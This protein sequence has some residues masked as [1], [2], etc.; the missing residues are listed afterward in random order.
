MRLYRLAGQFRLPALFFS[1]IFFSTVYGGGG[2]DFTCTK[3][4]YTILKNKKHCSPL[5][6]FTW[7]VSHLIQYMYEFGDPNDDTITLVKELF[8][9][10]PWDGLT[11]D[12][13]RMPSRLAFYF[14]PKTIGLLICEI[15]H[16]YTEQSTISELAQS[17]REVL[18]EH[19]AFDELC[20]KTKKEQERVREICEPKLAA[21]NQQKET[22]EK[23]CQCI[24][25]EK[26]PILA[27]RKKIEIQ[28]NRARA[29][30]N[31]LK[32]KSKTVAGMQEKITHKEQEIKQIQGELRKQDAQINRLIQEAKCVRQEIQNNKDAIRKIENKIKNTAMPITSLDEFVS[33]IIGAIKESQPGAAQ[34]YVPYTVYNI[35]LAFL[36]K[37]STTK[38]DFLDYFSGALPRSALTIPEILDD[39]SPEQEQWL[40]AQYERKSYVELADRLPSLLKKM[41]NDLVALEMFLEQ[42]Y[43]LLISGLH[44]YGIYSSAFPPQVTYSW[45]TYKGYFFAD[46]GSN[47]L[48]NCIDNLIYDHEQGVFD[49]SVFR[50]LFAVRPELE[51][52]YK[53]HGSIEK[54]ETQQARDAWVAVTS[55]LNDDADDEDAIDYKSP[56]QNGICEI[57]ARSGIKNMMCVIRKLFG[58]KDIG[59]LAQRLNESG[60]KKITVDFKPNADPNYGVFTFTFADGTLFT[61]YFEPLHFYAA[62]KPKHYMTVQEIDDLMYAMQPLFKN[63]ATASELKKRWYL[64]NIVLIYRDKQKLRAMLEKKAEAIQVKSAPV[65]LMLYDLMYQDERIN[66]IDATLK[67]E[68]LRESPPIFSL[69]D[70]VRYS[71]AEN[72]NRYRLDMVNALLSSGLYT[73]KTYRYHQHLAQV[74]N[75]EITKMIRYYPDDIPELLDCIIKNKATRFYGVIKTKERTLGEG[76]IRTILDNQAAQLYGKVKEYFKKDFPSLS[77]EKKESII[78]LIHENDIKELHG[79]LEHDK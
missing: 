14:T 75:K 44:S 63:E 43:E 24:E 45:A 70:R 69:M 72:N 1:L 35:F 49:F 32:K 27:E 64:W 10:N 65:S 15:E 25:T 52:F 68:T 6:G 23:K 56:E 59:V 67:S 48:R 77:D 66:L 9:L 57:A 18:K 16:Y 79:V 60:R 5:H 61:W 11:F 13:T 53:D 71:W 47:A 28:L 20:E 4:L 22:H 54:I 12:C 38:H 50:D 39:G 26:E 37:K 7:W 34:G 17:L 41:D 40:A 29:Q 46:C 21:I 74:L 55:E 62:I 33:Y 3:G 31:A 51:Q 2:I 36:W 30:K 78:A 58:V 73:E 8:H 76:T 42:E 19:L